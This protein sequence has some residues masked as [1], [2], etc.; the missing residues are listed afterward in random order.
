MS[1]KLFDHFLHFLPSKQLFNP[2]VSDKKT[3]MTSNWT[4]VKCIHYFKL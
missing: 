1:Y 4:S 2:L 3:I